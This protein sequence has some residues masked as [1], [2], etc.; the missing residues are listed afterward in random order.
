M[1][2]LK[3]LKTKF[4]DIK[5]MS[6]FHIDFNHNLNIIKCMNK[7]YSVIYRMHTG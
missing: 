2:D 5:K 6:E 3:T 1:K 4:T 7:K